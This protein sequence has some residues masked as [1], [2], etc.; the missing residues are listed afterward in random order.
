MELLFGPGYRGRL[1][2][3]QENAHIEALLRP[4]NYRTMHVGTP[5]SKRLQDP[6]LR[7]ASSIELQK[8]A[9]VRLLRQYIE[10]NASF[11]RRPS[12]SEMK[13]LLEL[14][15]GRDG[16]HSKFGDWR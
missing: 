1:E 4:R 16:R 8:A 5:W 7:Q 14:C 13:S 11:I 12:V 15:G 2:E 10:A 3:E 9:D 6:C